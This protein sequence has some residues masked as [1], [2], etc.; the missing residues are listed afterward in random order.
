MELCA[1]TLE[2]FIKG[3]YEGPMPTDEQVLFQLANGLEH[4]HSRKILHR[5][6]KPEIILISL[7]KPVEMKWSDFGLSKSLN[8][9]RTFP[10]SGF[11]G[12]QSWMS[13]EEMR[14]LQ[15][16]ENADHTRPWRGSVKSDIFSAGCVFMY[17]LLRGL[18]PFGESLEISINILE[19]RPIYG[20][21]IFLHNNL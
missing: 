7:T 17:F 1:A 5:N 11:R 18:H 2:D 4:I 12:N 9:K 19:D 20:S 8:E 14:M 10:I 15:S 3:K 21:L 16:E 13:P 6:I